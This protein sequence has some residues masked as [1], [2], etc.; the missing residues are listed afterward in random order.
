MSSK[1]PPRSFRTQHTAGRATERILATVMKGEL[2]EVGAQIPVG[3]GW[4]R[5]V[6]SPPSAPTFP[7]Q[8]QSGHT[9]APLIKDL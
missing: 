9:T 8:T 3:F 4:S 7:R 1:S 5:A 6:S 2:Q